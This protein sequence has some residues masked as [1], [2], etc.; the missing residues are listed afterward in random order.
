MKIY[1]DNGNM[2]MIYNQMN[3]YNKN[4]VP[5]MRSNMEFIIFPIIIWEI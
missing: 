2:W 3:K 1:N 5:N 4:S